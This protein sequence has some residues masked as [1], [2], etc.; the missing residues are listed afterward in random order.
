M[1]AGGLDA[2]LDRVA[3]A[4]GDRRPPTGAVFVVVLGLVSFIAAMIVARVTGP[5][6]PWLWN[7]DVPKIDYP[8]ASFYQDALAAGRLPFWNDDLGLGFPLYAEGQIGAFYPPNWL[9]FQLDPLVALDVSRVLHLV[10]AGV[11]TGLLALRLT[12]SRT[13]AL[14]AAVV[15]V[16]AG[17]VVAKLEWHNVIAAY[18]F[19]PW[20]LI[21][22]VRRPAPTRPGPGRGGRDLRAPGAPRPPEHVAADRG[23]RDRRHARDRAT[24]QDAAAGPRFRPDRGRR[25][26][27][28]TAPDRAHPD[29]VRQ[30]RRPVGERRLHELGDAVRRAPAGLPERLRAG[31]RRLA[32]SVRRCGTRTAR[33][34]SSRRPPTS[35][36]RSSPWRR[37]GLRAPRARP[38]IVLGLVG[39]AIP[40]IGAFRPEP[41]MGIPFINGLRSPVRSYML[42]TFA[43]AILAAIGIGRLGRSPGGF[44]RA[45]IGILLPVAVYVVGP[46]HS[47]VGAGRLRWPDGRVI[48]LR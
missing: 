7:I 21:P 48:D 37:S 3:R 18:S 23:R 43:I 44:E 39:I 19:L 11:G 29:P 34:G 13:G 26:G 24:T 30:E 5:N 20:I 47:Q 33:S 17:T 38:W 45:R 12:G 10:I 42:L 1:S 4:I 28:P 14:L 25:R 27:D 40:V 6:G 22:L 36:S 46:R 35:G 16:T 15:A 2:T 8:R 31:A 32:G 9:I 41:W